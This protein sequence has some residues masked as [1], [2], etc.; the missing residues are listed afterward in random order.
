MIFQNETFPTQLLYILYYIMQ[1]KKA[2]HT[3]LNVRIGA[4]R[5]RDFEGFYICATETFARLLGIHLHDS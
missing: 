5:L 1:F 4:L 2:R 3:R